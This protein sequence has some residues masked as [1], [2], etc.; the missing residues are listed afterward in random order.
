MSIKVMV[1]DDHDIVREGLRQILE[2]SSDVKVIGEA[3]NG[4]DC[5][6]QLDHLSPD[7]I[8]MDIQMPGISGI[9]TTR[10]ARKKK[11]GVRV[12]I[13]TIYHDAEF[14]TEAIQAGAIGYV[15][16][17]VGKD[18]LHKIIRHVMDNH[19]FIDPLVT[20]SVIDEIKRDGKVVEKA[21]KPIFTKR[22][23]E[24]MSGLVAGQTD[25]TIAAVLNISAHTV[26]SHIKNIFQK[27][28]VG[29]K[30]QA[31]AAILRER[32]ITE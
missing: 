15:L 23:L 3:R 5:L 32:I 19:A 11:P 26:R 22:E 24:V 30:S 25:R 7:I 18:E 12:I 2:I 4:L 8:F 31:V 28:G 16:K 6:E 1:V 17:T 29:T 10:L 27:L 20:S 21:E 13:L 9:E 14:V